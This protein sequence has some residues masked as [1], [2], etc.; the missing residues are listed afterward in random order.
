MSDVIRNSN[1]DGNITGLSVDI[2]MLTFRQFKALLPG[3]DGQKLPTVRALRESD[4]RV[5]AIVETEDGV[6]TV[7]CNGFFM[8]E[9]TSGHAT[10]YAIDRCASIVLSPVTAGTLNALDESTLDDCPWTK[11][12]EFAANERIVSNANRDVERQ[13]V[14]SL[15]AI[16]E[17]WDARRTVQPEFET[18]LEEEEALMEESEKLRAALAK[19]TN[20]QR[21]IVRLYYFEGMTQENIASRLK[22]SQQATSKA[23][24]QSYQKIK[25]VFNALGKNT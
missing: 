17:D 13:E 25:D 5:L 21:E 1:I 6:L 11:V 9:T 23:L 14:L 2:S 20:R 12:L 22:I 15:D 7:F 24:K 10:V 16:D 18:R 8:Y 19:L 3:T 4:I